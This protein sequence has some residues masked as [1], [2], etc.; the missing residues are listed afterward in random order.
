[1]P[2]LHLELSEEE[3]EL[4]DV[5]RRQQ[6]LTTLDQAAEWLVKARLRSASSRITGRNRALYPIPH[7]NRQH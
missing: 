1:M 4:L 7:R 2:E 3:R 5:V 6:G